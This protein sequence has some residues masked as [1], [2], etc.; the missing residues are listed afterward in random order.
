MKELCFYHSADLDGHCSGAIV[1]RF[2]PDIELIGINYGDKFPWGKVKNALV[3]MV[4]FSLQP[5][6]EMERLFNEAHSVIWMDHHKSAIEEYEASNYKLDGIHRAILIDGKAGCEITWDFLYPTIPMPTAVR[7]LGRYDVWDHSD[8]KTMP[9]QWGMR[10]FDTFPDKYDWENVF[11]NNDFLI[12]TLNTGKTLLEYRD[13]ENLKYAKSCSFETELDGLRCIAINKMLTNSQMFD[14]VW[15]K[16][17]YDA[18]LT[19]GW[20]KGSWTVSLYSTKAKIDVSAIAKA[21]GGGG[22]KG[23][24]GFQC[25]QLP[26]MLV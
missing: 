15:D 11:T 2:H 6:I 20:R 13:M 18:M 12:H 21:R 19:F 3:Y 24:A 22:H 23:A 26:F 25:S 1:K 5:F 10:M 4:D 8:Q 16:D 7:L 14:S 17:K 9:F